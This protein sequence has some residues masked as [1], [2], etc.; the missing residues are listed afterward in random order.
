MSGSEQEKQGVLSAS[1]G[2]GSREGGRAEAAHRVGRGCLGGGE[3][4]EWRER[5]VV[6]E[7]VTGSFREPGDHVSLGSRVTSELT[8]R[9]MVRPW[10]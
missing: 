3:K 5:E 9:H 10:N 1:G 8:G 6:G 4:W 2:Q 7:G